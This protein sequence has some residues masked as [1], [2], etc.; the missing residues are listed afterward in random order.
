M[1]DQNMTQDEAIKALAGLPHI[2]YT[3]EF[4]KWDGESQLSYMKKL[5]SALNEA[6]R[7]MMEERDEG[8]RKIGQLERQ[9]AN[10]EQNLSQQRAIVQTHLVSSNAAKQEYGREL[11]KLRTELK[12]LKKVAS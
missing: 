9:V 5:S 3:D 4:K 7:V 11:K 1:S 2:H 10:A 8:L 6:A 12:A